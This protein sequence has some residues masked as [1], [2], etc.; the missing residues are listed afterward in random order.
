M[1]K[2]FTKLSLRLAF[3]THRKY[4]H[5][6]DF[7]SCDKMQ[8]TCPLHN[9]EL[10]PVFQHVPGLGKIIYNNLKVTVVCFFRAVS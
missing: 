8:Q 5:P 9:L 2:T 6:S 1:T 3:C 7:V 4:T 10:G